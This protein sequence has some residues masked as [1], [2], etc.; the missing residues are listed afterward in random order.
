MKTSQLPAGNWD[1]GDMILPVT[2]VG[3]AAAVNERDDDGVAENATTGG[4]NEVFD[5]HGMA[6]ETV[7]SEGTEAWIWHTVAVEL[8]D[9]A[10]RSGLPRIGFGQPGSCG[11]NTNGFTRAHI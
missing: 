5:V 6:S 7:G 3:L 11:S 2:T 1:D 8:S 9:E 4:T 10:L